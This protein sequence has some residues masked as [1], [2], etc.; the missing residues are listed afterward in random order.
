MVRLAC[1]RHLADMEGGAARGLHWSVWHA[2]RAIRFFR[3]LQHSKGEKGRQRIELEGWQKFIVGSV[4]GW[5]IGTG[6]RKGRRRFRTATV[7]VAKKNGKST[8]LGGLGLYGM[9]ADDEPGAE[10][11]AAA[12]KREQAR[13]VFDAAAF[14]VKVSPL[15]LDRLDLFKNSIVDARTASK[16]MPL[17][18]DSDSADGINP[19]MAIVDELH[20]HRTRDML[21]LLG[22]SMDA[23]RQPLIWIITT[24]GDDRPDTPYATEEDYAIKVLEGTLEDD[25]YFAYLAMLDP[26]DDWTDETN[27]IKANPN[28]GV[29]VDIDNLRGRA[30]KAKG[31]PDAQSTFKRLR[32][33]IRTAAATRAVDMAVWNRLGA[34]RVKASDDSDLAGRSCF[35]GLDAASKVDLAAFVRWFPP[36]E[37]GGKYMVR[38]RFWVPGDNLLD[39]EKRDRARYR[40]WV[41]Q[42]WIETTEGNL[43]DHE[44]IRDAIVRD[45]GVTP[46]RSL[47][48]DPWNATMLSQAVTARGV[49]VAEFP[50]T[51]RNYAAAALEFEARLAAL[52]IDHG[53]NPVLAWMASNLHWYKDGKDNKMPHKKSS[54]GRIDGMT[55]LLMAIGRSVSP[56][57]ESKAE[58]MVAAVI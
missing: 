40:D 53:G 47:A 25:S 41:A 5:L 18:A 21:N 43:I 31:T 4:Y 8:M 24:A 13:L 39:R 36:A 55:A 44:A 54:T 34:T 22:E 45:H 52:D 26:G 32:L 56:E 2:N 50:Q 19:H 16:F 42:G 30:T 38:A 6:A 35:A 27:W 1:K 28:L 51:V 46:L 33:N 20:R 12:T 23:R 58:A 15:M 57:E 14:M 9:L 7:V 49:P 10:I 29:S 3:F 11:Y 48:F 17:G 37:A